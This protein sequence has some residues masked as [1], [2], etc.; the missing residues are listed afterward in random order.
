MIVRVKVLQSPA[1]SC[2]C[3]GWLEHWEN[4]SNSVPKLCSEKS[5]IQIAV[6][7]AHVSKAHDNNT[8]I[9]PVCEKHFLQTDFEVH[10]RAVFIPASNET[11]GELL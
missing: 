3:G 8:F 7:G 4:F 6:R 9:I 5:C 11:C 10:P 2:A 1:G